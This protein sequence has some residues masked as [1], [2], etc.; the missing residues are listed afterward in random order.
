MHQIKYSDLTNKKVKKT[1][2]L[3][4]GRMAL[5][6]S[7]IL[8]LLLDVFLVG[9][10]KARG[11]DAVGYQLMDRVNKVFQSGSNLVTSIWEPELKHED[12]LTAVLLVGIDSREVEFNGEEFINTNPK[13]EFGTRNTDT[14]IQA[15]YDHTNGNIFLISI[16]RDMGVD[17]EKECLDFHGSIHWVYDKGQAANCPGGGVQTLLETVE[18]IT[19]IPSQYYAFVTLEAFV[20]VI[21]AVGDTNEAGQRGIWIDIPEPVFELYPVGDNGWESIYFPEGYQF[22]TSEDALK[23]ARSRKA[24]SD[25]A[26]ARR[27]QMVIRAIKDRVLSSDTLLNPKKIYSLMQAFKQNTLFS[28]PDLEEI[29]AGLNI[30]RDIDDGEIINIVLDPDLGGSREALINK[31]PHDRNTAQY[32]MVPTHWADCPENVF[33]RVQEYLENVIQY[34]EVYAEQANV[35]VYAR[36]YN[37]FYQPDFDQPDYLRL[38]ANGIPVVLQESQYIA[39]IDADEDIVIYDFSE[40]EKSKTLDALATEL[41]AQVVSGTE[42]AHVQINGEDIAIVVNGGT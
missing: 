36:S 6:V 8:F 9:E 16:P 30:V 41:N 34:P 40:G 3:R 22:L 42:A 38:R 26:R 11:V 5:I 12:N 37:D 10:Y 28:E 39:N 19:G 32:Y 17:V 1:V 21:D 33:C 14:I 35:F 31:Q 4:K 2:K 23:F 20:D 24:S 13:P 18:G 25:F 27:Q 29:R 7:F 15:V